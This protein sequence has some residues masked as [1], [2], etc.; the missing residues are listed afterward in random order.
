MDETARSTGPADASPGS[1]TLT[2]EILAGLL[3][4]VL[5][6][7]YGVS[8]AYIMFTGA[9]APF[10]DQ[11]VRFFLLGTFILVLAACFR[12]PFTGVLWQPQSIVLIVVIGAAQAMAA[13]LGDAPPAR[14]FASVLALLAVSTVFSGVL[15]LAIGVARLG[16]IAQSIPYPVIGGFIAATGLLLILR[17]TLFVMGNGA[18]LNAYQALDRALHWCPPMIGALAM[19]VLGRYLGTA[20]TMLIGFLGYA[21]AVHAGLWLAGMTPAEARAAGFLLDATWSTVLDGEPPLLAIAAREADWGAVLGRYPEI[22]TAGAMALLGT[23]MSFSAIELT[24]RARRNIDRELNATGVANLVAGLS[25]GVVGY[26]SVTLT[27]LAAELG[28][29][30]GRLVAVVTAGTVLA[31]MVAGAPVFGL[32]PRGLLGMLLI[33]M[34]LGFLHRWLWEERARMPRQD[35]LIVLAILVTSVGAGFAWAV[36]VGIII[37]SMRF[38]VAYSRLPAIRSAVSGAVRLS[39]TE[40]SAAATALLVARGDETRIIELQGYMFFGTASSLFRRSADLLESRR[41]EEAPL[42]RMVVDFRRVH[43]MDVSAAVMFARLAEKAVELEVELLFSGAEPDLRNQLAAGLPPG[44]VQFHDSLDDALIALEERVLQ[45]EMQGSR[46]ETM[47]TAEGAF[48][49]LLQRIEAS[50]AVLT[51]HREKVS[52]GDRVFERG[53]DATSLVLLER[54]RLYA[55]VREG[56]RPARRV[57]TFLPG[58]V[59]GEIAFVTGQRRTAT[60]VAQVDSVLICVTR[61]DLERLRDREPALAREMSELLALLLAQRLTRTTALL[62]AISN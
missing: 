40:R 50:G 1:R 3:C 61:A 2:A 21:V 51:F 7:F 12:R 19:M 15:V 28:K 27:G 18:D 58:A 26:A 45:A 23:L 13:G 25:G 10:V 57:A 22:L 44:S 42:R 59:V 20:R 48:S 49:E 24:T 31:I 55:T 17:A 11:G 52:A 5:A 33:Y 35:Y 30:P 32:I 53:D 43:G 60:V 39:S 47:A 36:V 34:G 14:L 9:L 8:F 62:H 37:A 4:G 41:T 46:A 56:E 6:T 54:G 29:R 16:R 38:T